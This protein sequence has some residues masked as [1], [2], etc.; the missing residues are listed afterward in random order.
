MF[1]GTENTGGEN[2]NVVLYPHTSNY[3]METSWKT[4]FN[5]TYF[6]YT[7]LSKYTVLL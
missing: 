7:L 1:S 6:V 5:V 3:R 4:G 2:L